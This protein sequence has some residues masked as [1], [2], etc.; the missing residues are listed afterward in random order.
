MN[1]RNLLTYWQTA[2]Q[3]YSQ[4]AYSDLGGIFKREG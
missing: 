4:R 3:S 2:L 1:K